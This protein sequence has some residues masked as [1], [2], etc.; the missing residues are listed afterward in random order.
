MP[1]FITSDF[2]PPKDDKEFEEM[3]RDLFAAHWC[4]PN[5]KIFGRSG[6]GQRGVDVYGQPNQM[7][8]WFGIQCKVR[9]TGKLTRKELENELELTRSF[10]KRLHTYVFATTHLRDTKLQ[11]I[12]DELNE[13]EV[14][15]GGFRVQIRFWEDLCSLLAENTNIVRKY[16]PQY[17]KDE[18]YSEVST[19]HPL[20]EHSSDITSESPM[21][22]GL[23][24]DLSRSM[25]R[26]LRNNSGFH[27]NDLKEAV[28]LVVEKAASFCRTPEANEI[29]P[30]F[31]LFTYGYG[32]S[33]LRKRVNNVFNRLLGTDSQQSTKSLIPTAP[34]RDLFAEVATEQS[35]PFTPNILSLNESWNLYRKSVEYQ[36]LDMGLGPSNFYE[37]LCRVHDRLCKELERPYFKHP[38]V[39][40][41]SDGQVDDAEYKDIARVTNQVQNLGVQVMHC[42]IG[43][44]DITMPKVFYAEPDKNWPEEVKRLFS[45]SSIFVDSNPLL[46][47]IAQ[48]AREKGW[49]VPE[50]AKLFMQ[51]NQNEM[52]EELTE[53]LLSSLKD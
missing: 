12:V 37:S 3:V 33:D 18:M 5:T 36:F 23:V 27:D 4:D 25:L 52:L 48:E 20:S 13:I 19:H 49:E 28:S 16:Y 10:H 32:F 35:L 22:V 41:I 29:L 42:Y 44:K 39:V 7:A 45:L 2:H 15:N 43:A 34:V 8:S 11:Q 6:Q 30:K 46:N 9:K 24:I 17:F 1:L 51:I 38:L 50:Q 31:A 21:L 47:N 53:I 40:F 26:V 14:G